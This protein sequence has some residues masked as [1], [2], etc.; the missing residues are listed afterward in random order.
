MSKEKRKYHY[1]VRDA[2]DPEVIHLMEIPENVYR[3]VY[4]DIWR[5]CKKMQKAGRCACP[6]SKVYLCDADCSLCS[7]KRQGGF[8]SLDAPLNQNT[9]FKV[10]YIVQS[11]AMTP[12]EM[13]EEKDLIEVLHR[14]IEGLDQY[15]K[16]V[17]RFLMEGKTDREI[18]DYFGISQST[19]NYRKRKILSALRASLEGYISGN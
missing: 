9:D 10:E 5:I 13:L 16:E 12:Q 7:F 15:G 8:V 1:P 3:A 19:F 14:E 18:A 4:P 6:G 2:N 11:N 17:C